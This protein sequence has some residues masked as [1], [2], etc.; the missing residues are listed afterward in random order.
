MVYSILI[1]L[2]IVSIASSTDCHAVEREP[3]SDV[4]GAINEKLFMFW[5]LYFLKD[6]SYYIPGFDLLNL[7]N[8]YYGLF[9]IYDIVGRNMPPFSVI[10]QFFRREDDS[11]AEF[12]LMADRLG[13]ENFEEV[14]VD[15][16][17][18]THLRGNFPMEDSKF[19]FPYTAH[20]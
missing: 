13:L 16:N 12:L 18:G 20:A 17:N 6:N 14:P 10:Y 15:E 9:T 7:C 8:R 11:R 5:Y 3:L 1:E 2:I 19:I 4:L